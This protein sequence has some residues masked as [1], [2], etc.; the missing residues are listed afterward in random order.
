M[1]WS[2]VNHFTLMY[3]SIPLTKIS[4]GMNDLYSPA[5]WILQSLWC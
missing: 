3:T 5:C 2:F 4:I 1:S